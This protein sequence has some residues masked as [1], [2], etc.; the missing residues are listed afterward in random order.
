MPANGTPVPSVL[1][2]IPGDILGVL[3]RSASTAEAWRLAVRAHFAWAL[4]NEYTITGLLRDA[5]S[6][7]SFY[8]ATRQ[9]PVAAGGVTPSSRARVPR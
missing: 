8:L 6:D 5:L 3:S 4:A 1:I 2:E 9:S 7:R